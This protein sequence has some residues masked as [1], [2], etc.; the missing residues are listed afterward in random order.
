MTTPNRNLQIARTLTLIGGVL[1]V[2]TGA[3]LLLV[4]HWFFVN[5]GPFPPF[6]RHY[7]GDLGAFVLAL[8]IA[9]MLASRDPARHWL[10]VGAVALGSLIHVFNHVYDAVVS[11]VPLAHLFTDVIP[12]SIFALMLIV[13][14]V[15]LRPRLT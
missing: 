4:P 15:L 10:V 2:L 5:I 7:E 1:N 3:A 12:L 9:L 14:L 11:R 8:G 6:N 13:A